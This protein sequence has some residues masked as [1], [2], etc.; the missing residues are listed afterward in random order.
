M[1]IRTSRTGILF[2]GLMCL[3]IFQNP[4]EGLWGG[5][6]Y[7]DEL[8]SIFG[9]LYICIGHEAINK[10]F[11]L[12]FFVFVL[13]G[14]VGNIAHNYQPWNLVILDLFTNV[15][16]YFSIFAGMLFFNH[17]RSVDVE[18]EG[19]FLAKISTGVLFVLTVIDY[20]FNLFPNEIRY[21]IR[22]IRLFY[23]HSTYLAAALSL[24][25]IV[26]TL[27]PRSGNGKYIILDFL[28]L[29][30][31]LR[32][33]AFAF[34]GA[35]FLM[36][37]LI[38]KPRKKIRVRHIV[39]VALLGVGIG[40][41]QIS[42]Y[43]GQLSGTSARSIILLTS[44]VIMKDYFPFGTGFGTYGSHVASAHVN[45]SPIYMKYGFNMTYELRNSVMGTFFDDQFWP[46]IFGQTGV[47]GTLAYIQMLRY[48]TTRVLHIKN[49]NRD[50]YYAGLLIILYLLISSIAE[51]AFNN[52]IAV[53][54][55]L[56]LGAIFSLSKNQMVEG[57]MN[58]EIQYNRTC[59]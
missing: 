37:L 23:T 38:M 35:Y 20:M 50:Q 44:F 14:L 6:S 8:V 54:M 53:G 56:L 47:I 45:Y 51:P 13:A 28:M 5:F 17:I 58:D 57:R 21:G 33:K 1:K 32:S 46:I 2:F 55:A 48:I 43:F 18:N 30:L 7:V 39:I 3:A 41:S 25:I 27:F 9:I 24:L 42:Y 16:F 10:K 12:A 36:Y 4:L 19:I 15:K 29:L 34:A 40:Y 22:S 49:I 31:T 59:L 26:F 11:L 52:S